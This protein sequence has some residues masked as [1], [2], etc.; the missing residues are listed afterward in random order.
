M[1][2]DSFV[3]DGRTICR[4]DIPGMPASLSDRKGTEDFSQNRGSAEERMTRAEARRYSYYAVLAG[5]TVAGIVGGGTILFILLL[6]LLW[7]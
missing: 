7:G 5:L 1:K 3:D 4:M 6:C 2:K